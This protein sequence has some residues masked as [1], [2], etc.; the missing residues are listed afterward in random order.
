VY[1][2]TATNLGYGTKNDK[3]YASLG[4][5]EGDKIKIRGYRGSFNDK[6]EVM[7]A[8]FIEK[9]SGGGGGGDDTPGGSS[10]SF[11]TNADAQTWA[12]DTDGTYGSGFATTTQGLKIGYY[13]HTSTSNPVA[14]NANHIRVYKNSA[15]SIG[16]T[17]GKKIKKIV[18]GCAPNAGT[19]SYCFD[20]VG[21]EGGASATADKSALTVSWTG[22]ASKVVLHASNGQVRVEKITV[23]FE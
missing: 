22:S 18:L 4:L 16:S 17:G 6:I 8:W 11:S 13:K 19:S 10:V 2:L 9:V 7:Y 5:N 20:M 23:E 21:L 3:S 1:G 14:P 15:L 12:A